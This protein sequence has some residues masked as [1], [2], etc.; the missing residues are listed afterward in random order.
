MSEPLPPNYLKFT[1]QNGM[2]GDCAIAAL[3]MLCGMNYE[4]TLAACVLVQPAVLDSGMT[5]PDF[6]KAA[7][8]MGCDVKL[9]RRGRYDLDEATGILNVQRK[10]EDHA[11]FLWEGRIIEGNGEMWLYPDQYLAHYKYRPYSLLVRVN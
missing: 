2:N 6:R 5:W 7:D 11:V 1:R 4:E 9:L 3:A 10:G 8:A